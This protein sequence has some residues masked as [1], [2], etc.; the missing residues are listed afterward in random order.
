MGSDTPAIKSLDMK[1][2]TS[3][4]SRAKSSEQNPP[5]IGGPELSSCPSGGQVLQHHCALARW[6]PSRC[7]GVW[8]KMD[9]IERSSS[10]Q[11]NSWDFTIRGAVE[12][13]YQ[14]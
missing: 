7:H 12:K 5:H 10:T 3:Q 1:P 14:V 11:H 13:I 2:F 9:G 4:N 6:A 8:S